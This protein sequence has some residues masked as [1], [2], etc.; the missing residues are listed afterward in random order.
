MIKKHDKLSKFQYSALI[1]STIIGVIVI[2]LPKIAAISAK[3][4][5]VLSTFLGGITTTI[6]ALCIAILGKRFPDNTIIEYSQLLLGKILGKV[7][8]TI[9]VLYFILITGV[10]LRSFSD[11]LKGL[12]L[13]NTPLEILVIS[14]LLTSVYLT[15][16]GIN[17]IAK[18]SEL[19]LPIVIISLL[20][21]IGLSVSN[22]N[23]I[24]F[25][26]LLS[27]SFSSTIKGIFSLVTAFQ[28]YEI[29]FLVIPFI[30]DQKKVIPYTIMGVGIPTVL[31]TLLVGISIGVFGLRTAQQLNYPTTTLAEEINFAGAFIERFDIFFAILWILAVFTTVAN[32]LYMSS[33]TT[34]R[35]MGLRNYQPIIFLLSPIIYIL[36]VLPQNLPEI[37][38]ITKLVGY[39]GL[40]IS[41]FTIFLLFLALVTKKEAKGNV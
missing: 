37:E 5:A 7:F 10:V 12:L 17:G 40:S 32:F 6:I 36:A 38:K 31:Y 30:Y 9:I 35:L 22:I 34:V 8:G 25:R 2:S 14:M 16:N 11:A 4:S 3:E 28:G 21:V 18:L 33:L 1:S 26:S 29:I 19:F 39:L 13:K 27:P 41:A 15:L 20:L 23:P 24:N